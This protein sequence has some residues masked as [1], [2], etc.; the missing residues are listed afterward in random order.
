MYAIGTKQKKYGSIWDYIKANC[1]NLL[2]ATIKK[3]KNELDFELN[4]TKYL[5]S[6]T[7]SNLFD[8]FVVEVQEY[9][10]EYDE[11]SD[12]AKKRGKFEVS[13]STSDD[14]K[15]EQLRNICTNLMGELA[16]YRLVNVKGREK[17]K[18][19][20]IPYMDSYFSI[21]Q[22]NIDSTAKLDEQIKNVLA[23]LPS[24]EM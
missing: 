23:L 16:R 14:K 18:S 6:K 15:M 22:E 9:W 4:I 20:K 5:V 17:Q 12:P 1:S 11:N 21:Y 7:N 10:K 2:K 19:N 24:N 8:E 3:K 13:T